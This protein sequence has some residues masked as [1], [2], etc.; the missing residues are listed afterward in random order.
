MRIRRPATKIAARSWALPSSC[1]DATPGLLFGPRPLEYRKGTV[2]LRLVLH[3]S[4]G[5]LVKFHLRALDQGEINNLFPLGLTGSVYLGCKKSVLCA[6]TLGLWGSTIINRLQPTTEVVD[7]E[8]VR[9]R[10]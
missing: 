3:M 6:Q 1:I 4:G 8:L 5:N 2:G 7:I 9:R 10:H